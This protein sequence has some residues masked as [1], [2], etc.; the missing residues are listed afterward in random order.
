MNINDTK[1]TSILSNLE[2]EFIL[3]LQE[4][5]EVCALAHL[6]VVRLDREVKTLASWIRSSIKIDGDMEI[7]PDTP[8]SIA[9]E[10][11]AKRAL[12]VFN[13]FHG[14]FSQDKRLLIYSREKEILHELLK[15]LNLLIQVK[16]LK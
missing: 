11:G 16:D 13:N 1:Y 2:G 4:Y 9:I 6:L 15:T 5:A 12:W 7:D 3:K 14:D 10:A 8:A